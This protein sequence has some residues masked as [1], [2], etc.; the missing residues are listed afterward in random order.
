LPV[1]PSLNWTDMPTSGFTGEKVKSGK[2]STI[3]KEELA[4]EP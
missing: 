1:D 3:F 2:T 4:F